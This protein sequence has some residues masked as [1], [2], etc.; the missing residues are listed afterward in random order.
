MK[1]DIEIARSI[2]LTKIKQVARDYDIPVEEIHNY[3]R[4][5]A[6]VPETLIDEE[7]V[8]QSNLILVTA[9]TPTKAGIGKTTVSIGLAL[10]LTKIGKKAICALRE[11]S[12]GPC[13][14]MKGGAAGGGYAQVLPMD[15]INLHFTGDFHAITSAHNMIAAL[16]DNYMYQN[17]DNGFALKEVLW[18]RVLDVNDRGLRYI[19]TGLGG[20]TNGITR[21][22]GF[23]ITPASEIMAILCLAKD[24]DDLR[25][26]IE[27]ILLG[28]TIDNKPF[29]VKELGVAGAITVLLKDA[30]APNLV[31][32]TEHTAAFVHG[33][34]FANIAHG[35]NSVMATKLAMTFGD[36][37]ITEAGF[38]ADLGAEK[39]YD[40]KCR[41]SGLQPK[42][43][44][45]VA[46]AQG[47]KMHGGVSL[48]Q[49]KEPNAEGLTKGL[50]N[51]DKHIENLR[52]FGQTVVV[53]FNRYAND[54]EEEID[55]VRQHCAAQGIGFAVNNAFVEGGNGAVELANLVVD[56]IENQPSEPLRLAYNDDDTVEEKISKVACNL[57]GA[58]MITYSAAAKKKLKRIQELGYGH[59]PI[60][61]AKTQ[62]SFSTDPKLYGVVKDFEFHVRDIVLNAGAEMLVIIAGEIMRMPGLPKEPQALH[63]D[64]VNGEI[65]GLS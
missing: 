8:K 31:Q 7:K 61:I 6:K 63:I 28:F 14:G 20:K 49:I 58:N 52:S 25:R 17:Q 23:D 15:K 56:T 57:Y 40:I 9:I 5:I 27:N 54:T 10:G 50:A 46:T 64:I 33:G 1:S 45:I 30:I 39:F 2:E 36:Y 29:T 12:L 42:L 3:G 19:I 18:N 48:D 65:E 11:P 16:L 35:C 26:R 38:G 24:E 51:L 62:Y 41:K 44:I 13:F 60:C 55:L 34:P 59:F 43:T 53:A 21:E 4:Y 47:L 32:T 37:V 22:S